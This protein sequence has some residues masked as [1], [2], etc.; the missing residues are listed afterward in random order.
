MIV[1]RMELRGQSAEFQKQA[2]SDEVFVK[3]WA[4]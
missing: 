1:D 3:H 4:A 2:N